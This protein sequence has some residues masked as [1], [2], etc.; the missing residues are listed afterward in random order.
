[1]ALSPRGSV[2]VFTIPASVYVDSVEYEFITEPF[3][4]QEY[5]NPKLRTA[6]TS[7]G[8]TPMIVQTFG[9]K[10]IQLASACTGDS[11]RP[12]IPDD[13]NVN[14]IKQQFNID[15]YTISGSPT[16]ASAV[17]AL[18]TAAKAHI[19]LLSKFQ[20][21]I[22]KASMELSYTALVAMQSETF[23]YLT[24]TGLDV[25]G[26]S[27]GGTIEDILITRFSPGV[28]FL[29]SSS[30][31]VIKDWSMTFEVRTISDRVS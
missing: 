28:A 8:A 31:S 15:R 22:E 30:G 19:K 7:S 29:T 27:L 2:I 3:E 24:S 16:P 21:H 20:L 17:D 14:S 9:N 13:A 12:L 4:R 11:A 6:P 5:S 18:Y 1:M 25:A 26:A 10:P 23:S